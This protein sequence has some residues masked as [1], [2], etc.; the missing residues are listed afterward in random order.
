MGMYSVVT[1]VDN[2]RMHSQKLLREQS[3]KV[4][5][6]VIRKKSRDFIRWLDD[7]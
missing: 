5:R 2:A 6:K 4:I 1:T 7:H 3:F